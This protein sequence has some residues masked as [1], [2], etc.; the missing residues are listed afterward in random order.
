LSTFFAEGRGTAIWPWLHCE[1]FFL[2]PIFGG[3]IGGHG[4]L[5]PPLNTPLKRSHYNSNKN[6][7]NWQNRQ[8]RDREETTENKETTL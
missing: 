1:N 8:L 3:A 2:T 6:K 5:G 4:P 7:I